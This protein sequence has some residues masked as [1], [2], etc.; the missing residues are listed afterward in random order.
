MNRWACFLVLTAFLLLVPLDIPN[1]LGRLRFS[2][3]ESTNVE[4]SATLVDCR[5]AG[6]ISRCSA[7]DTRSSFDF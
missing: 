7:V 5:L 3:R 6:L 2:I 4:S 1:R